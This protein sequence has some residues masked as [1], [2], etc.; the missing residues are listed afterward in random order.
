M[1]GVAIPAGALFYGTVRRRQDVVFDATL[2]AET[3]K[4]ARRL[5]ELVASGVTPRAVREPKCS[6]CSLLEICRP[7]APARSAQRYVD[8]ALLAT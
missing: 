1:L 2:R 7:D 3:E 5:H 8:A 6:Q 4:A